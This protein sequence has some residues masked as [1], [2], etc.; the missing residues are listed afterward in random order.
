MK[1][2]YKGNVLNFHTYPLADAFYRILGADFTFV[3]DSEKKI[4]FDPSNIG[5][6]DTSEN[7]QWALFANGSPQEMALAKQKIEEADVLLTLETNAADFR[8]RIKK[9]KLTFFYSERIFKNQSLR[10]WDPRMIRALLW[11]HWWNKNKNVFMLCNS[12]FLPWDLH[13]YGLYK[14]KKLKWGYF[15]AIQD[16][17]WDSIKMKKSCSVPRIIWVGRL[18]QN[19]MWKHPEYA[20]E[21][22]Y[23]LK[24][25]NFNFEMILIGGGECYSKVYKMAQE[26][27]V[28]DRI[29]FLGNMENSEVIA[30]LQK[31]DI[32]I[33]T[34]DRNEGWGVALLEAM[35]AG[36]CPVSSFSAGATE[37]LI[38]ENING[39]VYH[40]DSIDDLY[41]KIKYLLMNPNQ[42]YDM[43]EK[44]YTYIREEYNADVAAKRLIEFSNARLNNDLYT[45]QFDSGPMSNAEIIKG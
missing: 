12:A 27:E 15:P 7:V 8:E 30:W 10:P 18:E 4:N 22:A 32:F 39:L 6:E 20:V 34:S 5:R 25:D 43:G 9:N 40:D 2:V 29:L 41:F 31:S 21:I 16:D 19:A 44:A 37:Y 13:W 38:Q 11:K 23:K 35:A 3:T 42:I 33:F 1:V 17:S 24:Q 26:R 36:C 45:V 28:L 14:N